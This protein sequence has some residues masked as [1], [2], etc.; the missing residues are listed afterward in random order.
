MNLSEKILRYKLVKQIGPSKAIKGLKLYG[1][2]QNFLNQL[3]Q[4]RKFNFPSLLKTIEI[5]DPSTY[6]VYGEETYPSLL[7]MCVDAPP[8]LFYKG[9]LT[10]FNRLTNSLSIVGSRKYSSYGRRM[11][12]RFASQAAQNGIVTVSGLALGIDAIVHQA[13]MSANGITVAVIGTSINSPYPSM[14]KYIYDEIIEN[15]GLVISETNY[16][17]SYNKWIF[18]RRNRI[19]AGLTPATLVIEAAEKSGALITANQA[20]S[21]GRGVY[22][23]PGNVDSFASQG[24]FNMLKKK[25]AE[26]ASCIQDMFSDI[27]IERSSTNSF[28]ENLAPLHK[29]LIMNF[30]IN[31][32]YEQEILN[33]FPQY[34]STEILAALGQLEI[35]GLLRREGDGLYSLA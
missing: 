16:N 6:I 2:A 11:A 12:E 32:M 4:Q 20:F 9:N 1:G 15:G 14:N 17:I 35:L 18:P 27:L 23:V 31:S 19:I 28:F 34:R 7:A 25:L 24:C 33:S 13:T 29:E 5:P 26:P 22:V 21:Y 8:V 30:Q 3:S 10:C